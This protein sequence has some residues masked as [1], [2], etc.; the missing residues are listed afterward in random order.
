MKKNTD[1][2]SRVKSLIETVKKMTPIRRSTLHYLIKHLVEVESMNEVNKMTSHNLAIVFAP[3]ILKAPE[4][5]GDFDPRLLLMDMK[6]QQMVV[7]L[8][9][10]HHTE[11]FDNNS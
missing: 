1:E 9:I 11:I 6:F 8:L 2:P 10:K 5:S 7:D 4:D 3:T